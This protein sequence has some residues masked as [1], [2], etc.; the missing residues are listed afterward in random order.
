MSIAGLTLREYA[1]S[2]GTSAQAV[3]DA[4]RAALRT[5][6]ALALPPVTRDT[7]S[8]GTR[9]FCLA[10]P[11]A[12]DGAPL[13]SESVL[14]PMR[15]RHGGTGYTL[16]VSSQVGCRMGCTFCETGRMGLLRNLSAAEIVQQFLVARDR[17]A[18]GAPPPAGQWRY[19][20]SGIR[21]IVFM[22]MGEPFDN[23]DAVVQAIRVLGEPNGLNFP[24]A[25]ITVSTV[26]RIDGLRRLA[27][28]DWPTLRLAIS[29]TAATDALRSAL[30]PVNRAMPLAA[31]RRAL[32]AYPFARKAVLM[33]EVVLLAGVNDTPAHARAVAA[34]CR[35]LRC[36]VNVIPYNPQRA[37]RYAPPDEATIAA[38]IATLRAHGTY[39]TRRRTRGR[40]LLGACGQLGGALPAP[41][42][43]PVPAVPAAR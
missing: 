5:P 41:S 27:A 32:A 28:L 3:R 38:F 19:R 18:A 14:I 42:P 25:Q 15:D 31:L 1:A 33:I 22:G 8:D 7:E 10:V 36:A 34:W 2:R 9:K 35:G 30:M 21:N 12:G 13:A 29:L 16:C 37:A 39:V 43:P 24:A 17:L 23:F 11:G 40:D 4:Y 26:G 20:H 6:G